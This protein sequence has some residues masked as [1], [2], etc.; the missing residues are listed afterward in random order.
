MYQGRFQNEKP[1]R[2]SRRRRRRLRW[3]KQFAVLACICVLL[4]GFVGTT[5]AWLTDTAF[6]ENEFTPAN[7]SCKATCTAVTNTSNI[8]A[9]IRIA[10]IPENVDGGELTE[11]MGVVKGSGWERSG[12]YYI[13]TKP[14]PAGET[15]DFTVKNLSKPYN[16]LAEAIQAE[17]SSA[18]SEAWGWSPSNTNG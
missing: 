3:S 7:V 5:L 8:P 15:V 6:V 2:T 4:M 18:V 9:Y 13:Y 16:V 12:N 10:V 14:V 11:G 1:V 17:P